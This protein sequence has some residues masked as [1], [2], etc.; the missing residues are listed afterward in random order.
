MAGAGSQERLCT[1]RGGFSRYEWLLVL[2]VFL[3]LLP[4]L[5]GDL[6]WA[7]WGRGGGGSK[8]KVELDGGGG[9]GSLM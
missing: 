1:R 9:I 2:L 3:P 8:W 6:A 4:L 5:S 7:W